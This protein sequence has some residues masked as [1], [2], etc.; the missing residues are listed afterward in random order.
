MFARVAPASASGTGIAV[1]LVPAE[2]A[3]ITVGAKDAKMGQDGSRTADVTFSHVRVGP[4][5]LVGGDGEVGYRA[6]MTSLARGRIHMAGLAVG[7]AQRALDESVAYAA[8]GH[9]GRHTHR[10]LPTR[11]GDDRR[12]ADR[13]ARRPR[14][15]P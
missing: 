1:F 11:A 14:A 7:P 9:P 2:A 3:G 10:E 5:A 15:R 12:P 4:E 6:A 13:C 8:I